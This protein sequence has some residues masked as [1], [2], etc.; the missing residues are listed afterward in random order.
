LANAR[1]LER[2]GAAE[3][4]LDADLSAPDLANRIAR[5]V[6]DTKRRQMMSEAALAWSKP[7]AALKLAALVEGVFSS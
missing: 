7:E 3:V 5:L 6:S 4:L 2:A 1:E